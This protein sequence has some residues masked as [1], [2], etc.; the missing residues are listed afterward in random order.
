MFCL[1]PYH[2]TTTSELRILTSCSPALC[3]Q[4]CTQWLAME[5]GPPAG[6]GSRD[7]R[8]HLRS[9]SKGTPHYG[10]IAD[11]QVD[12]STRTT[13]ISQ[14]RAY[15]AVAILCYVNLLNYMDRYTIAGKEVRLDS[16]FN[17]FCHPYNIHIPAICIHLF[18]EVN[19]FLLSLPDTPV[20]YLSFKAY[21]RVSRNPST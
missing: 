20:M 4:S 17:L 13:G 16:L 19:N 8:T 9:S 7:E 2:S 3:S 18:V 11:G 21:F 5:T 1:K 10:T 6:A 12:S 15:I 14:R